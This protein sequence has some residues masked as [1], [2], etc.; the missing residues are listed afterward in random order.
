MKTKKE[1]IRSER[2]L[3]SFLR[4]GD[5]IDESLY[6]YIAEVVAPTYMNQGWVQ[7]GECQYS[8]G[9]TMYYVTAHYD[10]GRTG[11]YTYYGIL[12]LFKK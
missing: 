11:I 6:N 7:M 12:P 4:V 5:Q 9:N 2:E 3:T 8:E 1:W 10:M